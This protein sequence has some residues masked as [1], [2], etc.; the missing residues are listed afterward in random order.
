MPK[1]KC[2][3]PNRISDDAHTLGDSRIAAAEDSHTAHVL[4][5]ALPNLS[6]DTAAPLANDHQTTLVAPKR[7]AFR[8]VLHTSKEH[9]N[10]PLDDTAG[11][12]SIHHEMVLDDVEDR[13]NV[14]VT[15]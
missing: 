7:E 8:V 3:D 11:L 15:K 2:T 9:R 4:A 12:L 10:S 1:G 14:Q 5:D 13:E 6:E